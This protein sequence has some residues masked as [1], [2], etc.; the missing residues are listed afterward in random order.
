MLT[1][2]GERSDLVP[3]ASQGLPKVVH[4]ILWCAENGLGLVR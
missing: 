1:D 3:A 2:L 4:N